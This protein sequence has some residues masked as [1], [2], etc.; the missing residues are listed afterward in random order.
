MLL[1]AAA[2]LILSA[3]LA[4]GNGPARYERVVVAPGDTLWGMAQAR[5]PGDPRPRVDQIM[6][7]NQLT[8]PTLLPGQ[9]LRVPVD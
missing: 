6:R 1:L 3:Q 5:Y 7:I 9:T 2:L 4:Y 8:S